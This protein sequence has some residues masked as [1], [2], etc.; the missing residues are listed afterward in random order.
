[1]APIY[2]FQCRSCGHI[3]EEIVYALEGTIPCPQCESGKTDKLVSAHGGYQM[4][5]GG[6]ST[7]PRRA[8]AFRKAVK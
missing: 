8:G 2:E 7:R 1:M 6:S 3:F 5:S 4:S